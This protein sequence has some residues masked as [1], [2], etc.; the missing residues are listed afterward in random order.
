MN[1]L[2]MDDRS[3]FAKPFETRILGFEEKLT[4]ISKLLSE[5]VQ[6]Q[7]SW[8]YLEPIF[9]SPD[10]MMQLPSEGRR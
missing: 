10:I 1:L 6:M 7:T 4:Y 9:S 3:A 8:M 5:W 2:L